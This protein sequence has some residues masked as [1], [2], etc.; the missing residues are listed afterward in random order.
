VQTAEHLTPTSLNR[1]PIP[2]SD[3]RTAGTSQA[4]I[5]PEKSNKGDRSKSTFMEDA[6][7]PPMFRGLLKDCMY[8]HGPSWLRTQLISSS[9]MR[10][11]AGSGYDRGHMV[12]A[13]DAS[14]STKP[15]LTP[16]H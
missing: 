15:S 4:V 16:R 3:P 8:G 1:Q 14:Q 9:V 13:A 10:I 11:D 7:V 5:I 6:E 2:N 12:P